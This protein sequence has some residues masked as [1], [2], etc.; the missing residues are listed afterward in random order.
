MR[1]TRKRAA[2]VVKPDMTP[3]IDMTFQLIAFFM[4]V[5]N[6]SE[7]EQNQRVRLP[8]SELAKPPEG[9]LDDTITLH[10]ARDEKTRQT[11]V[12]FG[13]IECTVSQLGPEL[14]REKQVRAYGGESAYMTTVIIRADRAIK[15]G[16]VQEVIKICQDTGYEK[17]ALRAKQEAT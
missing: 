11:E 17:F 9:T 7:A 15:T 10:V 16:E 6:F 8:L 3:M 14:L 13:A 12:I 2:G 1:L 4:V 5:V